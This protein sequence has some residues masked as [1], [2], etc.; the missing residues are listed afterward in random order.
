MS[1]VFV[2]TGQT[3]KPQDLHKSINPL[4]LSAAMLPVP[5]EWAKNLRG[6]LAV[7]SGSFWRK[8][9]AAALRVLAKIFS[10]F[11]CWRSLRAV[12]SFLSK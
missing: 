8:D 1:V 10:P 6:R 7:I 2:R 9:P 12:K 3:E 5:N 4:K 11:N